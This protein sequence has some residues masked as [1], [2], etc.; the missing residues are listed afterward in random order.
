MNVHAGSIIIE[1]GLTDSDFRD[2]AAKGVWL[3]KAGF[4]RFD[5]PYD[6]APYV[7]AARKTRLTA[8]SLPPIRPQAAGS[9]RWV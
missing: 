2:V 1:P 5:D 3:A 8:I 9:C 4:G 7:A 6:Y